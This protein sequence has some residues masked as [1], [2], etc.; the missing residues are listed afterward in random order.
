MVD[1]D[2]DELPP[3]IGERYRDVLFEITGVTDRGL[4]EMA[5]SNARIK[6]V[7]AVRKLLRLG[8]S[9]NVHEAAAAM[10]QAQALMRQHSINETHVADHDDLGEVE[11]A[12]RR[13]SK[14]P[15]YAVNLANAVARGFGALLLVSAART[16]S[17]KFFAPVWRA[18][19]CEYAFVVLLRQ[20]ERD[21]RDYI[22]RVRLAKNRAA[23]GDIFGIGW[24][25]G[26]EDVLATWLVP[27]D[28]RVKIAAQI[29]EKY[30]AV[31]QCQ[32]AA[33]LSKASQA[34]AMNDH[35]M[36][37]ERGRSARLNRGV[38][39]LRPALTQEAP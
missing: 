38:G 23:R 34:V 32:F 3:V 4:N 19:L 28:E 18:K 16:W 24:A 2:D 35:V 27:D 31:K 5:K 6:A 20:L 12:R 21:R 33:R 25:R 11:T 8:K 17:I 37:L 7:A 1:L 15:V 29:A 9:A 36:G 26:V 39:N 10:R 14:P 22:R 30:P 13:G